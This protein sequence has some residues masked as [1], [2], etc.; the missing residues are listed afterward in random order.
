VTA[1]ARCVLL[2]GAAEPPGLGVLRPLGAGIED[3]DLRSKKGR[4][5]GAVKGGAAAPSR[6][7]AR[8][9]APSA[10]RKRPGERREQG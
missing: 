5:R 7:K 4:E 6:R 10:R 8:R 2:A 9:E 3:P 1:Q